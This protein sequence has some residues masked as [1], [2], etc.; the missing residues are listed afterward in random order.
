MPF[1]RREIFSSP[2]TRAGFAFDAVAAMKDTCDLLRVERG[3]ALRMHLLPNAFDLQ[4][5]FAREML[6]RLA[7]TY[8]G[9]LLDSR[10]ARTV[11]L[12]EASDLGRTIDDHDPRSRASE[13][14][15]RLAEELWSLPEDLRTDD[16]L[17]WDQGL[18]GPIPIDRGVVFEASFP[19]A[20][21]VAVT[22]DFTAWSVEGVPL[23]RQPNGVWRVEVPMEPGVFEYK[24]I[25]DGVWKVDPDNPERLRNSYG[26]LNSVLTVAA[27][28]SESAP[29]S[30]GTWS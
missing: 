15:R 14:F 9:S 11:R 4:T 12:R 13:D 26:Q 22:G 19:Q 23:Q 5:R 27:T 30:G 25:V 10:I 24:F 20:R 7:M 6:E 18:H 29:P 2:W 16:V 1:S 21:H 3:H 8:P 17:E 28:G